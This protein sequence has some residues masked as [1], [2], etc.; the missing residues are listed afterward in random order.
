MPGTG[1]FV[2]Y[3]VTLENGDLKSQQNMQLPGRD[4]ETRIQC[5][6]NSRIA[7]L[8]I[9]LTTSFCYSMQYVFFVGYLIKSSYFFTLLPCIGGFIKGIL[10]GVRCT[11]S[12]RVLFLHRRPPSW[13]TLVLYSRAVF[14]FNEPA[15]CVP[16]VSVYLLL[17]SS[18][19]FRGI[20][21]FL[22]LHEKYP[23]CV[24]H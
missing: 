3:I 16:V 17:E 12:L 20:C 10:R 19:L 22:Q 1:N 11:K 18:S 5:I 6:E 4:R 2:I 13:T 23:L 24:W 8:K 21:L 9:S 15:L 7:C 14:I